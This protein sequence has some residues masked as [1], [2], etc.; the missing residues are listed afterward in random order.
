MTYTLI[1]ATL[2]RWTIVAEVRSAY[3]LSSPGIMSD[4]ANCSTSWSS[5]Q[6]E[7][8]REN[9]NFTSWS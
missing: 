1:E 3:L 5:V 7:L 4:L 8:E 6:I 9:V 2:I